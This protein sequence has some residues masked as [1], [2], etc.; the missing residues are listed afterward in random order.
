VLSI[1][2]KTK[3]LFNLLLCSA[4]LMSSLS[5]YGV[6]LS[7]YR[8]YLDNQNR[9]YNFV[10]SNRD[11]VTQKCHL[12]ITHHNIDEYGVPH[13]VMSNMLPKNSAVEFFRYS[14]RNFIIDKFGEQTVRFRLRKKKNTIAQEYRSYLAVNCKKEHPIDNINDANNNT[15]GISLTPQLIHQ[16][17]IIIRPLRLKTQVEITDITTI[18]ESKTISFSVTRLGERSIF[19]DIELINKQNNKR[20]DLIKNIAIYPENNKKSFS[21][22]KKGIDNKN[23]LIRLTE[24]KRTGGSLILEKNVLSN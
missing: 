2:V 5:A 7:T 10:I 15:A 24:D 12:S 22:N 4:L 20:I 11:N 14:P 13:M 8:I 16:V 3:L 17:P 9:D 1:I 23:L 21:L 19:A 6:S 18:E